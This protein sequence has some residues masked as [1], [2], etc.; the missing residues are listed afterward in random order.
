MPRKYV[1][2]TTDKYN[3]KPVIQL[4]LNGEFVKEWKTAAEACNTLGLD[5][6]AVLRAC[7]GKQKRAYWFVWKFK[8]DYDKWLSENNNKQR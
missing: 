4:K 7:K 2:K 6:S 3:R 1:R 5:K 8:D